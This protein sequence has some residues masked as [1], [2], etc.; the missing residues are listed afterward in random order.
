MGSEVGQRSE[1]ACWW[2]W[3]LKEEEHVTM[4]KNTFQAEE[5]SG[6]SVMGQKRTRKMFRERGLDLLAG[7][8]RC[9]KLPGQHL[10][11]LL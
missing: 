9:D 5:N 11:I 2:E 4:R 3:G 8:Q 10:W 6:G 7:S 1:S